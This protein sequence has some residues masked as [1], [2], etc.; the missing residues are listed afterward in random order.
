MC[1][2]NGIIDKNHSNV[3]IDTI[4][5]MNK[6]ISHR[7][8]D[9]SGIKSF[10]NVHLGHNRLKII[11][12]SENG[13]QPMEYKNLTILFNGE[14]YNY[15]E[16][17]KF[18]INKG[19]TF[20]SNSDTE[21]FLK[22]FHL[23]DINCLTIL[24]G[25]FSFCIYNS[26]KNLL[27]FGR[28]FFGEKPFFY[29]YSE[30]EYFVFSSEIKSIKKYLSKRGKLSINNNSIPNYLKYLYIPGEETV[31]HNIKKLKPNSFFTLCSKSII[32]SK[33]KYIYSNF[34]DET[35]N[36]DD[37]KNS[38]I[39]SI[40]QQLVSD[41]PLGLWLSGG[42]DS[43]LIAAIC[44]KELNKKLNTFTVD[45]TG[46][47]YVS[48]SQNAIKIAKMFNHDINILSVD[49]N[50]NED[51][52]DE[53]LITQDDIVG[54]P[55]S[56]LHNLL[57][58]ETKKSV[59]VILNGVGGDELFGGY[60]RYKAFDLHYYLKTF[61]N[62]D[63][64]REFLIYSLKKL[65]QS[66]DNRFGNFNRSIIKIL[67]SYNL[68]ENIYYDNI[69]SYTS[70]FKKI[71]IFEKLDKHDKL[72]QIMILDIKNYL[73]N[74]LLYLGDLFSMK[75]SIEL[76]AP[77]L[78]YDLYTSAFSIHSKIKSKNV[79]DKT[80][81]KSWL[82]NY[83]QNKF[84]KQRK[85]GFTIPIEPYFKKLGFKNINKLL[86]KSDIYDIVSHEYIDYVIQ[87]FYKKNQ[88]F[89]NQLYSIYFLSKWRIYNNV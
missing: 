9:C 83:S 37:C 55:S 18:L 7:G 54:N 67:D 4:N 53:V 84:P 27:Y 35:S 8:P 41:V 81:L 69:I 57:C 40:N 38:L 39:K 88:D 64:F 72:N 79:G 19:Y 20:Q 50:I 12:L 17:K 21:V 46:K 45:F 33:S 58:K 25:M 87:G 48:E 31:Y 59:K 23:E 15:L 73:P 78:S 16:I 1:G 5:S 68:E 56:I 26:E 2:I 30:G 85:K 74:D 13:N 49:P 29:S 28:D 11:D 3:S 47:N 77:F 32:L 24:R 63:S 36:I 6:I 10:K 62:N 52:I 51:L 60:N 22:Y 34:K 70:K 82:N 80:I 89:V 66:R 42:T 65:N 61:L 71:K 44:N 86:Y 43:S 76:R 14:I 75:H